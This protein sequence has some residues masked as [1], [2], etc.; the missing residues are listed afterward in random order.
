MPKGRPVAGSIRESFVAL[1]EDRQ[2]SVLQELSNIYLDGVR[3]RESSEIFGSIVGGVQ[4][5]SPSQHRVAVQSA[6]PKGRRGRKPGSKNKVRAQGSAPRARKGRGQNLTGAILEVVASAG[7]KG[8]K[9]SEIISGV[10]KSGYKPQSDEKGFSNTCRGYLST[11]ADEKTE[12]N[13]RLLTRPEGVKRGAYILSERGQQALDEFR[14]GNT[15]ATD[16]ADEQADE[17][18]GNAENT[19]NA[20]AASEVKAEQKQDEGKSEPKSEVKVGKKNAAP[21]K[22]ASTGASA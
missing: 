9:T 5:A 4:D 17:N 13:K 16:K 21:A 15:E 19:E 10:L 22:A 8:A 2:K 1:T 14:K 20:P 6:T 12:D 18:T 7:E 11:L 3:K